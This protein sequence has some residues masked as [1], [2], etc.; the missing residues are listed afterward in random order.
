MKQILLILALSPFIL[1]AQ[2]LEQKT[3]I[4]EDTLGMTLFLPDSPGKLRPVLVY[5]HGGGFSGGRRDS[6]NHLAFCERFAEKGWATAT[7]S[8]HLTM[9][10]QSFSCDQPVQNKIR[11]IFEAAKNIHQAVAF[12]IENQEEYAI[13][14]DQI[15]IAGSSA[16]AEAAIHAVY[17]KKTMETVLPPDFRYAGV[18]SMA[19]ALLDQRWI[20]A[21]SAVPTA[22]FH[23]AC[24]NLVPYGNAPHHYCEANQTGF[25]MLYGSYSI[26]MRL[27]SLD[28][29]YYL[30]TDCG[31][32]HEW[33]EYPIREKYVY[34]IEDFLESEVLDGK[35]RQTHLT[36]SEGTGDCDLGLDFCE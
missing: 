36:V 20:T 29:S 14:P 17:W 12:L 8:Y 19:G 10:G 16:G 5:V 27:R 3:L 30:M 15:V 11:T 31:G 2:D 34:M 35:F 23:G 24:D 13:D 9:K 6:P 1:L 25:M 22:L 32:G 33:N 26:A 28:K 4:Y 7:I 18:I 21:A